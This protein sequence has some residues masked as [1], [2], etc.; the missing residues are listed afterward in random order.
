[1]E[2][3]QDVP[4]TE[5]PNET[6]QRIIIGQF[7]GNPS[8][9]NSNSSSIRGIDSTA[10]FK[11]YNRMC[12]LYTKVKPLSNKSHREIID[13]VNHLKNDMTRPNLRKL[14]CASNILPDLETADI[15]IDLAVDL[16]TMS[17]SRFVPSKHSK[18]YAKLQWE[19]G[20]LR[21]YLLEF[22]TV[23]P[24]LSNKSVRMRKKFNARMFVAYTGIR[25]IFTSNLADHLRLTTD[26]RSLTIF[27]YASFLKLQQLL[28][29]RYSI[30][31][32]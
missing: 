7:W 15:L 23:T 5:P 20:P 3:V 11:Y 24:N 21:D 2:A 32:S 26:D 30:Y 29:F 19:H 27:H 16:L 14:I 22:F 13:I 18:H 31:I 12:S 28:V 17:A 8:E 10:Y 4:L 1:M 25:I 6:L 9:Q